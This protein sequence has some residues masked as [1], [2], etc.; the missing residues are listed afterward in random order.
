MRQYSALYSGCKDFASIDEAYAW[1][2]S[3]V[4][5]DCMGGYHH[6]RIGTHEMV[7]FRR[8]QREIAGDGLFETRVLIRGVP[9][10]LGCCYE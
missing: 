9:T 1:M 6:A 5:E 2:E 8:K 7:G 10:M 4:D 3:V